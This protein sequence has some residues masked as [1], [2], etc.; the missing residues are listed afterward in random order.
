MANYVGNIGGGAA[1]G[2]AAGTSIMPGWGTAIGAG[3][4]ALMGLFQSWAE[5]SD[6]EA[7]REALK[8][9]AE[10][11]NVGYKQ[12]EKI[13]NAYYDTYAPAGTKED[14]QEAANAIRNFDISKYQLS[15]EDSDGN[16]IPD[17]YEFD[18]EGKWDTSQW[19]WETAKDKYIDPYYQDIIDKSNRAVQASAAGAA[20]GRSTGAAKAISENTVK[21][22]NGLYKDARDMFNQDRSAWNTDRSFEYQKQQDSINNAEERLK[23]LMLGDQ[24]KIGQ[25]QELGNQLLEF[26]GNRA[27]NQANLATS[28]AQTMA[29]LRASGL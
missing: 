2:A 8:R 9:A 5:S 23:N 18:K 27:S 7:K 14:I 20:L 16:G 10:E 1:T 17:I 28:K 22:Y 15:G 13:F 4:G 21:E 19:D 6:E 25:Q 26:E 12:A 29:N 3:A 11:M 24:W